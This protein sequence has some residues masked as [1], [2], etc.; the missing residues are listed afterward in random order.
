[1]T[2]T[3]G[4]QRGDVE[5]V[6]YANEDKAAAAKAARAAKADPRDA[7]A[8]APDERVKIRLH[9]HPFTFVVRVKADPATGPILTEMTVIADRD[10][11]VT[12]AALRSVPL[13]RLAYSAHRWITTD[14]GLIGSPGDY[15]ETRARPDVADPRLGEL[16]W[17]IEQAIRDGEPV[18]PTV[19]RDLGVS[20]KTLDRLIAKAKAEG[21]L[22]GV[23]LPLSRRPPPRQRDALRARHLAEQWLDEHG[24]DAEP[25]PELR[26][27]LRRLRANADQDTPAP[28]ST[29]EDDR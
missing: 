8:P 25:P 19:A 15:R 13:R 6:D 7:P 9:G 10:E 11:T 20:T 26:A 23:E 21:L 2:G 29:T 18:R 17:R 5:S 12:H 3:P 28:T 27:E 16:H 22:E 14:G 4:P 24:P 1:M